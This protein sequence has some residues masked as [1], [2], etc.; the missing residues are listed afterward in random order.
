[1]RTD[2][3]RSERALGPILVVTGTG[4][5]V[6][7]TMATAAIAAL[8]VRAGRRVAVCKPAQ[9]G[10]RPG[11]P[12]DLDEVMRLAGPVPA[13][14]LA[15]YP[16]PLAP[17]TAARRSGL[18]PLRAEHVVARVRQLAGG[19]DLV[20]VEGAGGMLVRLDEDGSTIADV[21]AALAAPLLVV[22][23]AGLGT[24][25]LAALTAEALARRG[26]SCLGLVVGSWPETP[27]LACRTNLADLPAVAGSPLVGVLPAGASGLS[28]DE[29][30][31]AA[32]RGLAPALGG[33][34]DTPAFT[35]RY[36]PPPAAP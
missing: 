32:E 3:D 23:S 12:G 2:A 19:V 35:K 4:T 24:L 26:L 13:V 16:E 21:A 9:T 31:A 1:M 25:N 14:E 15:R 20:L 34:F 30:A 33:C 11:E 6:G 17:D 10:V 27:D 5:E 22:V 7:K 8:A 36:A 18:P 29:F 28:R